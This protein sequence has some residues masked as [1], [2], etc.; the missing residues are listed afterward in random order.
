MDLLVRWLLGR[1]EKKAFNQSKCAAGRSVCQAMNLR[2]CFL[3]AARSDPSN[4]VM[5]CCKKLRCQSRH[6]QWSQYTKVG[7]PN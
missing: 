2:C 6:R 5:P 3:D 4:A 7:T 1:R